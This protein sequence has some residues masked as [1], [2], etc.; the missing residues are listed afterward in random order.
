MVASSTAP[1][2]HDHHPTQWVRYTWRVT[3]TFLLLACI[4]V[5][6]ISLLWLYRDEGPWV[7]VS[8]LMTIFVLVLVTRAMRFGI[9]AA[10]PI[11]LI[12]LRFFTPEEIDQAKRLWQDWSRRA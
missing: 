11:L 1:L 8:W 3:L 2:Y 9:V 6:H 12:G 5:W 10:F 4:A 7:L